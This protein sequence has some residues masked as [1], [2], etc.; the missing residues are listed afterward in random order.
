MQTST[1]R[2]GNLAALGNE[3][4]LRLQAAGD[5]FALRPRSRTSC[6]AGRR[7]T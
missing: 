6:A 7:C 1:A 5:A 4:S 2:L 3:P